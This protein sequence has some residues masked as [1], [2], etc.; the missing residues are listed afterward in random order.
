VGESRAE[1]RGQ[2]AEEKNSCLSPPPSKWSDF[3]D[4]AG[5]GLSDVN[6]LELH[7]LAF[8]ERAEAISLDS[9]V[10]D[11]DITASS[12]SMNP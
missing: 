3:R 5:C 12:R 7:G 8:L 11:E 1:G 6:D 4:V 9:R 2:R 10:V